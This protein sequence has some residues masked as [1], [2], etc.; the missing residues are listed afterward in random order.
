M[1]TNPGG[2]P[3]RLVD[4]TWQ[5]WHRIKA[6][7][8]RADFGSAR[9]LPDLPIERLDDMRGPLRPVVQVREEDAEAVRTAL[10]RAGRKAAASLLV[11]VHRLAE[12]YEQAALAGRDPFASK[13]YAGHE[14][15]WPAQCLE[16]LAGEVGGDLAQRPRRCH[17]AAVAE[18][19][20]IIH[21]WVTGAHDYVEVPA[22]LAALFTEVAEQR[23]GWSGMADQWLQPEGTVV[24]QPQ[25][26]EQL[27][28][29]LLGL[30]SPA[31][32]AGAS[33][34]AAGASCGCSGPWP[35]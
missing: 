10:R 21:S 22:T 11:A 17:R 5:G 13:L 24:Q 23:G 26:A 29:Y 28:S 34:H 35:P 19:G 25:V 14:G 7:T 20:R 33:H 6:D 16:F 8:Y 1:T 31:G 9:N 18:L 12:Q 32:Q 4:V 15:S 2:L 3:T 27:R 30:P